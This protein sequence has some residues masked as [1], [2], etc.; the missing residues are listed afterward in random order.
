MGSI[1]RNSGTIFYLL[2]YLNSRQGC[3][4]SKYLYSVNSMIDN[5][6][7]CNFKSRELLRSWT[8]R[9]RLL[10]SWV[11]FLRDLATVFGFVYYSRHNVYPPITA[12]MLTY[13][14]Q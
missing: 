3:N 12:G 1:I 9:V 8:A 10:A 4:G 7:P 14:V 13:G 11:V 5:S 2:L 6:L